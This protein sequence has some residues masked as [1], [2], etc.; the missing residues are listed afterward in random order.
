MNE[1]NFLMSCISERDL[2]SEQCFFFNDEGGGHPET[3]PPPRNNVNLC[4][5][6]YLVQRNP[7][8]ME[9][10]KIQRYSQVNVPNL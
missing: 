7:S 1:R 9:V 2:L 5:A 3:M 4:S 10:L 8:N 6:Y